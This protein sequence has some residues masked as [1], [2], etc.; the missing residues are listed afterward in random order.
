MV[1][2]EQRAPAMATARH[3]RTGGG[4]PT[5]WLTLT[6]LGRLYGISAMHCGRL[7]HD[8]GLRSRDGQPTAEALQSGCAA[9]PH[10]QSHAGEPIWHR[11]HCRR[12]FEAAGLVTVQRASLVQQW[13]AL[14]SALSDGSPSI[15]TSAAQMAEELPGELVEP[16]NLELRELG[17]SFQVQ[18]PG[19]PLSRGGGA[20]SGA[21]RGPAAATSAVQGPAAARGRGRSRDRKHSESAHRPGASD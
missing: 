4:D 8:A 2:S 9:A 5:P 12:A 7:L 1:A 3:S 21:S 16:V 15:S 14:L 19:R 10:R 20:R 17:C 18:R 6:D 11:Q 13:A